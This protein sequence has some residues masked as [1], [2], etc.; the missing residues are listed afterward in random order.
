M[1]RM[2]TI[3]RRH[4]KGCEHRAEGRKYRRCRCPIWID[5]F[6][7]RQEIRKSLGRGVTWAEAEAMLLAWPKD[8]SRVGADGPVGIARACD[9]FLEDALARSLKEKTVY[10]YRLLFGQLKAFAAERGLRFLKELDTAAL[11]KFRASW[12]DGNLAALKKLE[13]LRTFLKF[14][15]DNEWITTNPAKKIANPKFTPRPTLP[16][17]RDEMTRILA[18]ADRRITETQAHGTANAMRLRV[19]ILLLRYSGLR[20]GDAAGCRVETLAEQKLR[21]YTQKTGTHVHCP[22]P[23][24][25]VSELETV[26]PM[27]PSYWFWTGNGKLQTAIADWQARMH[28]V[29]DDAK[30]EKGHA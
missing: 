4:L 16:F 6:A 24:F 15:R 7:G 10:K 22:L 3:Y 14:A 12:K 19:L 1:A 30:I 2:L 21:L 18:E 26:P 23:Q 9:D 5:G 29:F 13:R 11:R 17:S 28:D 8:G 20:I 25:V 27:S